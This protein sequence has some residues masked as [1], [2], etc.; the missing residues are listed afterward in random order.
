[1]RKESKPAA[2][3]Q[4]YDSSDLTHQVY[5]ALKREI[6]VGKLPA[7]EKLNVVQLAKQYNVSRT[8]VTQ[9]LELLKQDDLI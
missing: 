2:V 9:A 4:E 7:M 3:R 6:L 1:M 5:Y 8:P